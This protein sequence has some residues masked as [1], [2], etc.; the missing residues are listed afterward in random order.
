MGG[1][2]SD[3]SDAA[4]LSESPEGGRDCLPAK[5]KVIVIPNH[6][7]G[8]THHMVCSIRIM[9]NSGLFHFQ[10]KIVLSYSCNVAGI[11]VHCRDDFA[12]EA[13]R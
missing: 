1:R 11:N 10:P 4:R 2:N 8:R 3:V 13:N 6:G 7:I 12:M 9:G 5:R